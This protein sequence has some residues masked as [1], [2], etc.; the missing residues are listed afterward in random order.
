MSETAA[1][2]LGVRVCRSIHDIDAADWDACAGGGNP[3]LRHAFLAALEDSGSATDETG[4]AAQ[5]LA[6]EDPAGGLLAVAPLYLKSHSYGEY[7]FDHGWA[8]A[9][10]RAGGRYYP[11]LQ[12]AV[13]FTPVTGPRLLARRDRA[14][15]T[16]ERARDALIAAMVEICRRAEASSVHVTFPDEADWRR[17][18]AAGFLLRTGCQF[19][20]TNAGYRD[21][22]DFLAALSARK[23]KAVKRERRAV[24]EAGIAIETLTGDAIRSSHWDDFFACYIATSEGK[25]G[26][27]YLT[28]AFFERL[29]E[30]MAESV[31]LVL[32]R[33]DGRVIAGALNLR[34]EDTL[35]GRN[36]GAREFHRFLHFELCYYR[37]IDFAIAEGLA[38]IEAGAQG[39]HK[40]ARGYLPERTYSA[41]WI[42]HAGLREAVARFLEEERAAVAE[43]IDVLGAFAPFRKDGGARPD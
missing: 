37:A 25:W 17:L 10:E 20:W 5:H 4:W 2:R 21:F 26:F 16:R 6:V 29:G 24:A 1:P 31:V 23:R 8:D 32:A 15:E 40:I 22:D 33:R 39:A 30:T 18:G 43:D 41:H 42:A 34:G 12:C 38:R 28:R 13:P 7:V 3:F 19:H 36:W 9:F 27:P 14:L 35:F 11:K